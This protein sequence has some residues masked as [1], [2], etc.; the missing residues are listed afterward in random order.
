MDECDDIKCHVNIYKQSVFECKDIRW[1]SNND[2]IVFVVLV[3]WVMWF[4]GVFTKNKIHDG[5]DI[6]GYL[7]KC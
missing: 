6:K 3:A 5:C 7:G 2:F 1:I 4:F